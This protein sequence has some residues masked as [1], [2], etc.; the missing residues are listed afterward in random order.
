MHGR[1]HASVQERIFASVM[2]EERRIYLMI[3]QE[4]VYF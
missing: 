4:Q 2:E 3:N 1:L